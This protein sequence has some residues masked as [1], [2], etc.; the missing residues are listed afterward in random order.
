[1]KVAIVIFIGILGAG[2]GWMYMQRT[3]Q[4][5]VAYDTRPISI[6]GVELKVFVADTAEKRAQGLMNVH[7]LAANSGM[8]F[9]F[10]DTVPRTFWNKNTLLDLDIIWIM[11]GRVTGVS[12]LPSIVRSKNIVIVSSPGSVRE[13]V[14]VSAGWINQHGIQ[15]GSEVQFK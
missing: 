8:L 9:V 2:F 4:P 11:N 7:K 3:S 6:G 12:V 10:P 1:M 13:V 15:P 14:E 5:F